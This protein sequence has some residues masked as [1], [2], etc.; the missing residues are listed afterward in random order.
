MYY[1][2][3]GSRCRLNLSKLS[4]NVWQTPQSKKSCQKCAVED[5]LV[6]LF[7][8]LTSLIKETAILL[9]GVSSLMNPLVSLL[10]DGFNSLG[11]C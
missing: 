3:S 9:V 1:H 6:I 11:F 7:K 4:N 8:T 5:H 2:V 10:S